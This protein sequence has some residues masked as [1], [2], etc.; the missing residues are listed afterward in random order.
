MTIPKLI[1]IHKHKTAVPVP[2]T[3]T[4]KPSTPSSLNRL[5]VFDITEVLERI[6]SFLDSRTI[7]HSVRFVSR[8]WYI[9]SDRFTVRQ[10]VLNDHEA[11]PEEIDAVLEQ[12]A[13]ADSFR[14]TMNLFTNERAWKSFKDL[15]KSSHDERHRPNC[16]AVS[17]PKKG[18]L[19]VVPKRVF[20]LIG[21][22]YP[23]RLSMVL[24][25]LDTLTSLRINSHTTMTLYVE[26]IFLAC[27]LLVSLHIEGVAYCVSVAFSRSPFAEP[28]PSDPSFRLESLTIR[29]CTMHRRSLVGLLSAVPRLQ[30]LVLLG[31]NLYENLQGRSDTLHSDI[32]AHFGRVCPQL[33]KIHCSFYRYHLTDADLQQLI[34]SH[35]KVTDWSF[36]QSELR[37]A[38]VRELMAV[39]NM[40]TY[41]ELVLFKNSGMDLY[42]EKTF[43]LNTSSFR[44]IDL[45]AAGLQEFLCDAPF[46]LHLKTDLVGCLV[47][48]IEM[49]PL[50]PLQAAATATTGDTLPTLD[51]ATSTARSRRPPRVWTCRNLQSLSLYFTEELNPIRRELGS[52]SSRVVF[53]YLSRVCPKLKHLH[54]RLDNMHLDLASGMCLL[55]R[56]EQLEVLKLNFP[57]IK[58]VWM[59]SLN[60]SWMALHPLP[61]W[62]RLARAH[63]MLAWRADL[64]NEQA[65]IAQ[66]EEYLR[67]ERKCSRLRGEEFDMRSWGDD[68]VHPLSHLGTLTDVHN[69]LKEMEAKDG[70]YQCWP[71]IERVRAEAKRTY[72][73][74]SLKT[75]A[76]AVNKERPNAAGL[77]DINS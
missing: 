60:L 5:S 55:S 45:T 30:E 2:P 24:P 40:I 6:F 27:S 23:T 52:A 48:D 22:F 53:G 58:P 62:K 8:R 17:G 31:N 10:V 36:M 21:V 42:L 20:H 43:S 3:I 47:R 39:R 14:W 54:L 11:K 73:H 33:C 61:M 50:L 1:L 74:E 44:W 12:L 34:Q 26:D 66:R 9:T 13:H 72:S 29:Q 77:I 32:L 37:P 76:A 4:D 68:L 64:K 67:S 57:W 38:L 25:Y 65:M 75:F 51:K 69:C 49:F 19:A 63:E 59:K 35:H 28:Q 70:G 41:L 46:L 71:R 56:M 16:S 7:L 15:L 18:P